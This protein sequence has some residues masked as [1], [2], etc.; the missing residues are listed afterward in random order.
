MPNSDSRPQDAVNQGG[1]LLH[2]ALAGAMHEQSRLLLDALDR[3]EAHVGAGDGFGDGCRIRCIVL[4]APATHAV[5]GDELGRHQAH[6]VAER[7]E[8]P[9]PVVSAGTGFHACVFR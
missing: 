5:G 8:L 1:A 2:I 3:H 6:G 7:G 4:A 9:G